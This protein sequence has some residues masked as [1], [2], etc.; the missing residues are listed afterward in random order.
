MGIS[1]GEKV[2]ISH[3]K[4]VGISQEKGE[5]LLF[6]T[7]HFIFKTKSNVVAHWKHMPIAEAVA[8]GN[9]RVEWNKN[10]LNPSF[11]W[12]WDYMILTALNGLF[13]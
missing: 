13:Y 3:E 12:P 6:P 8:L 4:K 5:N 11:T 1:H 9:L 10:R 2:G 7:K